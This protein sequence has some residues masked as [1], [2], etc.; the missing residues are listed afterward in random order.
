M[1]QRI[2][3]REGSRTGSLSREEIV[4]PNLVTK[5]RLC[6][7]T[8]N[9]CTSVSVKDDFGVSVSI[10]NILFHLVN[11]KFNKDPGLFHIFRRNWF[12][13]C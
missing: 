7:R 2:R 3:G 4:L 8:K 13:F 10:H 1:T 9:R 5:G 12:S 6:Q 11:D